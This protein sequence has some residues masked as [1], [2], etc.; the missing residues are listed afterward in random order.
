MSLVKLRTSLVNSLENIIA[1]NAGVR[2]AAE[3]IKQLTSDHVAL[4]LDGDDDVAL[5]G[6][7]STDAIDSLTR[8]IRT[9]EKV[10]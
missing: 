8:H 4:L 7:A 10:V 5:S 9:V 3:K 1:R 6:R 2:L